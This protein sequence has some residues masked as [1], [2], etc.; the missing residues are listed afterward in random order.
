MV[1]SR[2]REPLCCRARRCWSATSRRCS[3]TRIV[4]ARNIR[5]SEVATVVATPR[6]MPTRRPVSPRSTGGWGAA[7][8]TCHR[9]VR[10][11]VTRAMPTLAGTGR[12]KR[13]RTL[14]ILGTETVAH[15]RFSL[16]TDTSRMQNPSWRLRRR[17]VGRPYLGVKIKWYF[18]EYTVLFVERYP[19]APSCV[20]GVTFSDLRPERRTP[21]HLRSAAFSTGRSLTHA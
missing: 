18:A 5:P 8:L 2:R 9:P 7:K 4:G 1:A 19:T 21:P 20:P 13:N 14:L 16:L 10:S 15:L 17:Q 11:K 12:D 3:L 6:S